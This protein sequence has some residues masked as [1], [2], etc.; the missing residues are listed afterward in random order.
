MGVFNRKG[1]RRV[2]GRVMTDF[3]KAVVEEAL[4]SHMHSGG[5]ESS[6]SGNFFGEETEKRRAK[7][8]I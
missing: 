8:R 1:R 4:A 5:V 3:L 2:W 6:D 7:K